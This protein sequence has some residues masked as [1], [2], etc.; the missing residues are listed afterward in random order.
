MIVSLPKDGQNNKLVSNNSN[1]FPDFG[2]FID[3]FFKNKQSDLNDYLEEK[4]YSF[5]ANT[6]QK[7]IIVGPA[8]VEA[9]YY[10]LNPS[11]TADL[12]YLKLFP[13]LPDCFVHHSSLILPASQLVACNISHIRELEKKKLLSV[14]FEDPTIRALTPDTKESIEY[15][16]NYSRISALTHENDIRTLFL[17]QNAESNESFFRRHSPYTGEEDLGYLSIMNSA[18]FWDWKNKISIQKLVNRVETEH[19]H[20]IENNDADTWAE[21]F[22]PIISDLSISF[23][24]NRPQ[25]FFSG[26]SQY[27]DLILDKLIERTR[28]A[29]RHVIRELQEIRR[30]VFSEI[31]ADKL[32][33]PCS[34]EVE[35]PLSLMLILRGL[36]DHSKASDFSEALLKLRQEKK[37]ISFRKWISDYEESV[38]KGEMEQIFKAEN[39]V[40]TIV[41]NLRQ[42]FLSTTKSLSYKRI[43]SIPE[44]LL[45]LAD[46]K[47]A[48]VAAKIGA[49]IIENTPYLENRLHRRNLTY[50][51]KLVRSTITISSLGKELERCFG[52]DG[53][54][55]GQ[56]LKSSIE[57]NSKVNR[58]KKIFPR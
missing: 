58:I 51:Q 26:E 7:G 14:D 45:D 35:V 43:S 46:Q 11:S 18:K 40:K 25:L 8:V 57:L 49:K 37:V 44:I 9:S 34:L 56:K 15:C 27:V 2:K 38:K 39:E 50:L 32:V 54:I 23:M 30:A 31:V 16:S 42:E 28:E 21:T 19:N 47:Y 10:L 3:E 36:K 17:L 1:K 22:E 4:K 55:I 5:K 41:A 20:D 6:E 33:V 29:L 48:S 52:D 53:K 12:N 24:M 13:D